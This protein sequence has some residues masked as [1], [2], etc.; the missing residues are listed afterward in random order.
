MSR[1]SRRETRWRYAA[2]AA[3]AGGGPPPRPSVMR[4]NLSDGFPS[5]GRRERDTRDIALR[6]RNPS[7]VLTFPE[8]ARIVSADFTAELPAS[9][10][11]DVSLCH[12]TADKTVSEKNYGGRYF[13][14]A[15][16]R[17]PYRTRRVS[18]ALH[19]PRAPRA[20][21][22]FALLFSSLG[23]LPRCISTERAR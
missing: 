20:S 8:P 17:I 10:E 5:E 4:M 11:R 12:S 2:A 1:A 21:S 19:A 14:V 22:S 23:K 7:R 16:R 3:A 6:A 15:D 13:F 18:S 9:T